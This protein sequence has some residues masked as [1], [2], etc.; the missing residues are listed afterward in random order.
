MGRRHRAPLPV[1]IPTANSRCCAT[2]LP[3]DIR[4]CRRVETSLVGA[5]RRTG[6][7][8]SIEPRLAGGGLASR[9]TASHPTMRR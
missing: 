8:R 6:D 2:E 3:P 5:V 4:Q 1:T 7:S 9:K